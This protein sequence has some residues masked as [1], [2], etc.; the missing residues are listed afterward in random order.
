M[1]GS[2]WHFF[3]STLGLFLAF[4]PFC[5]HFG[6]FGVSGRLQQFGQFGPVARSQGHGY[7]KLHGCLTE[8]LRCLSRYLALDCWKVSVSSMADLSVTLSQEGWRSR[9]EHASTVTHS[10]I[11]S[12]SHFLKMVLWVF[13]VVAFFGGI[14]GLHAVCCLQATTSHLT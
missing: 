13:L 14:A 2:L 11:L 6:G 3:W 10:V 5:F 12:Q 4:A 7:L 8:E 1:Q 9:K